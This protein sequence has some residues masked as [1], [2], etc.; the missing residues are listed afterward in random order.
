[1]IVDDDP[2]NRRVL[3][4]YV[5]AEGYVTRVAEN[6]EQALALYADAHPDVVLLDIMMPGIDGYETA[7]QMKRQ[8]HDQYVPILMLSALSGED[9]V[10]KGFES[11]AD[12][13]LSKPY[14]RQELQ[15]RLQAALRTK[16]L[17]N[18]LSEK[19]QQL[20]QMHEHSVR[21][22]R[23]AERVMAAMLK[24]DLLDAPFI[25]YR[26]TPAEL[27]NGDLLMA[28]STPSGA[29]RVLLADFVGHGLAAAI[30][31]Q[32]VASI[33]RTMSRK[34]RPVADVLQVANLQ[35]KDFLP[36]ELFLAACVLELN[37]HEKT[38][39]VWNAGMPPVFVYSTSADIVSR[40]ASSY[41]PLG[42]MKSVGFTPPAPI[43]LGFG[44]RIY[45]YSDGVTEAMGAGG[46]KPTDFMIPS[47]T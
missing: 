12:D 45:L 27:F 39:R 2:V 41:V 13:F 44:D 18:T 40:V 4:R 46:V 16:R 10:A 3:Q 29:L 20:Q 9:D 11:G 31:N 21:D 5:E 36:P 24:S 32:P 34:G 6:G 14:R 19:K 23:V 26:S 33:F 37:P 15:S 30:G 47:G 7:R 25:R 35:L 8:L 28:E 42:I 38:L 43:E 17:F 1:M 22:Q